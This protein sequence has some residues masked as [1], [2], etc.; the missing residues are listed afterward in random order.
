MKKGFNIPKALLSQLNEF[1]SGYLLITVNE[2]GDFQLFIDGAEG[3]VTYSG[4]LN[5]A[6]MQVD[7]LMEQLHNKIAEQTITEESDDGIDN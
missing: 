1:T 7:C 3:L 2:K 5:Y 6:G 4:L